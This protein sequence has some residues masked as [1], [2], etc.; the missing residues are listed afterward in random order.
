MLSFLGAGL[1]PMGRFFRY[2]GGKTFLMP[3][4]LPLI[5]PHTIYVEVFGGSAEFLFSKPPATIEVY[6]DVD[7]E[8]VNLFEVVRTRF[9]EFKEH[10]KFLVYSRELKKR[11]EGSAPLD[12]VERAVRAWY[13]YMSAFQGQKNSGWAYARTV[14]HA[15]AFRR[16]IESLHKIYDRIKDC[17]IEHNDFRACFSSW[18]T[19]NTFFF[20]DPPYRKVHQA[21]GI[22]LTDEDY[23]DL[24]TC[25]SSMQGKF[26]LTVG[27]DSFI[28]KVFAPGKFITNVERCMRSSKPVTRTLKG[29]RGTYQNLVIRNYRK[30]RQTK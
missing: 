18:D 29:K 4:L 27:V 20:L 19:P 8:L 12:P 24:A 1:L 7:G 22:A 2:L 14:N 3:K 15:K 21:N 25:C 28:R 30:P 13:I 9:L 10:L 6:N 26:L 23:E 11:W 17:Y 16:K 5:P